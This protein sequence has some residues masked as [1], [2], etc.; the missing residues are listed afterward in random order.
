MRAGETDVVAI[1][2]AFRTPL[3]MIS[4]EAL[5][6]GETLADHRS[7]EVREALAGIAHHAAFLT[8]LGADLVDL[9]AINH[10]QFALDRAPTAM[11]TLLAEAIEH[12]VPPRDLGRVTLDAPEPVT[13]V[14]DDQRIER[15]VATLLHHALEHAPRT[16]GIIVR[17]EVTSTRARVAVTDVDPG[18][19][20]DAMTF[21]FDRYRPT[22]GAHAYDGQAL[23]LY[24]SKRIVDAHGGLLGIERLVDGGSRCY[25]DLPRPDRSSR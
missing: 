9:V 12:T 17:L 10:Q 8:R 19:S 1:A 20:L 18:M 3:S 2:N 24:V 21:V 25:F 5:H 4:L 14:I 23:G 15:V 13:L 11:R 16:S 6:L 22:A 7:A